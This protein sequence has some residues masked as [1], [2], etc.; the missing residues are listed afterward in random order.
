MTRIF[1]IGTSAAALL[2]AATVTASAQS[3]PTATSSTV[4]AQPVAGGAAGKM[5]YITYTWQNTM[6]HLGLGASDSLAK[7]ESTRTASA[8]SH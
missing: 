2:L 6:A 1:S 5:S 3:A 7:A 4:T 8:D